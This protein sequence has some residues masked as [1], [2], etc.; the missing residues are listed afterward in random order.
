MSVLPVFAALPFLLG[1]MHPVATNPDPQP[2]VQVVWMA[3]VSCQHG[4]PTE[5][6]VNPLPTGVS[7]YVFSTS[8]TSGVCQFTEA[9]G[10]HK[11]SDCKFVITG[12]VENNS[13]T[14]GVTLTHPNGSSQNW[15]PGDRSNFNVTYEQACGDL[16]DRVDFWKSSPSPAQDLTNWITSCANCN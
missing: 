12:R 4:G 8:A 14:V 3:C 9:L 6:N 11:T 2:F 10:C 7:L 1:G 15:G 13:T 5:N 16:W